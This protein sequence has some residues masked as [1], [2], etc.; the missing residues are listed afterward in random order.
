[1][2]MERVWI[3]GLGVVSPIGSAVPSFWQAALAGKGGTQALLSLRPAIPEGLAGRIAARVIDILDPPEGFSGDR[4]AWFADLAAGEAM[5]DAG[6]T[7]LDG[8]HTGLVFATAVGGTAAMEA[9]FLAMKDAGSQ[10]APNSVS[11]WPA[12]IFDT[13]TERLAERLH[14]EGP[15]I[16]LSTGCTAGLDAIGQAYNMVRQGEAEVVLVGASEAP[17][18]PIVYSAF[19]VLGALSKRA[20][21]P[22]TAS[23]PFDKDR[24]GFVL[25]E[26]AAFIVV[27]AARHAVRRGRRPYAALSGFASMSNATHMTDLPAHNIALS[28]CFERALCDASVA[29]GQIDHIS[30]HGSSTPQN[31]LCETNSIKEVLGSHANQITV[32]SLK[33][34]VGHA[35]GA[36]NAIEV[37]ACALSLRDQVHHPT[38]NLAERGEGC[39]LDYVANVA[40]A[41]RCRH[42]AKLS[43]GFSGI[44]S[45]LIM[46]AAPEVAP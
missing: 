33:S 14:F 8:N 35:L 18:C 4:H 32:N 9:G 24:D 41:A 22:E 46:S 7:D 2:K 29:R 44:H 31:D 1:M 6:L 36:S 30:A 20:D 21:K 28:E 10:A 27:E 15:A 13:V 43:N 37:V 19:D 5:R 3:T 42:I 40:R 25:G 34:M 12:M 23:R 17:I 16:T 26:G 39:D 38:I 45:T 11:L